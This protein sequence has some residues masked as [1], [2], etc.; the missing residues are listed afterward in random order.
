[1]TSNLQLS[2]FSLA[3]LLAMPLAGCGAKVAVGQPAA[4]PTLSSLHDDPIKRDE[5]LK[6]AETRPSAESN[7]GKTETQLKAE[8]LAATAAAIIGSFFSSEQNMVLGTRQSFDE[9]QFLAPLPATQALESAPSSS[10]ALPGSCLL[11]LPT[12]PKHCDAPVS[13]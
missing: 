7:Q 10:V 11:L 6:S 2:C 8:T 9:N 13:R 12:R 5:Q 1:M 4:M 3:F